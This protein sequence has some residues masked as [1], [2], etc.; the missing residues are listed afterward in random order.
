MI[1]FRLKAGLQRAPDSR[2]PL[3][4]KTIPIAIDHERIA[5]FFRRH[6]M[7]RL[8]LFGRQVDLN[9]AGWLSRY[10]RDEV[11]AG[12]LPIYDSESD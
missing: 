2:G 3:A 4:M 8:S 11:V 6:H 1:R 7:K 12:A 9:T 10:F 5:D